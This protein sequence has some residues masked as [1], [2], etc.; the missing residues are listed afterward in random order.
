MTADRSTG[1]PEHGGRA[2]LGQRVADRHVDEAAVQPGGH[3]GGVGVPVEDVEGR[4]RLA[5]QVVV[6]PVVP[7]QVVGP[8]PGEHLRQRAR[9]RG[10]PSSATSRWPPRPIPTARRSSTPWTPSSG[11]P[12]SGRSRSRRSVPAASSRAS[13]MAH[14]AATAGRTGWPASASRSRFWTARAGTVVGARRRANRS[15]RPTRSR[16]TQGL[17]RRPPARRGVRLAAAQRPGLELL[18]QQLPAR[19]AA[20][21]LRHP[22]LERRHHPDDRRHCTPTSSTSPSERADQP[23]ALTVLGMPI[24]LSKVTVDSYVMAGIADHI[25]PWQNCYR[26]AQLLGGDTRFVL[27]T[28]GHI[29]ALVNPPG[30]PKASFQ[31]SGSNPADAEQWLAQADTVQGSWWPDFMTWLGKRSGEQIPASSA[32]GGDD[33]RAGTGTRHLCLR[34]VVPPRRSVPTS[35]RSRRQAGPS[36]WPCARARTRLAAAAADERHRRQP[37]PVAALRRRRRP[38]AQV[39]RFD[40]PGVGGS[41]RPVVPYNLTDLQSGH[42]RHAHAAGLRRRGRRPGALLGRRPGPAL[43]RPVPQAR[44]PAGAGRHGDGLARWCR[45]TPGSWPGC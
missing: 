18:G 10:S 15:S 6:D 28:S 41:P 7:D 33:D 16:A 5:L 20:A 21:G 24:D 37:G 17:P 43:R 9:R 8:Q 44:P 31:V 32:L 2:G 3:P 19:Q 45:P 38:T 13:L 35:A 23:G 34:Q 36:G 40:V 22:V 29:A 27:S 11:P 42:R 12:A 25:T 26:S 14:L 30:N 1:V 4:R 39:I